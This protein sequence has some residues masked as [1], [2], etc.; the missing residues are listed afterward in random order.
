MFITLKTES[1]TIQ[2]R[3]LL[4]DLLLKSGFNTALGEYINTYITK[5]H[6]NLFLNWPSVNKTHTSINN[7]N[8]VDDDAVVVNNDVVAKNDDDG[9]DDDDFYSVMEAKWPTS[10]K[11]EQ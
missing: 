4:G 1:P 6:V 5:L 7:D 3:S 9:N 8:G 10:K 2:V 11:M